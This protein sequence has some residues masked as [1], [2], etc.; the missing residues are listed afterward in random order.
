M[1][2]DVIGPPSDLPISEDAVPVSRTIS[3]I[4]STFHSTAHSHTGSSSESNSFVAAF[5][6]ISSVTNTETEEGASGHVEPSSIFEPDPEATLVDPSGYHMESFFPGADAEFLPVTEAD[7]D[8]SYLAETTETYVI[9]SEAEDD[10]YDDEGGDELGDED[11]TVMPSNRQSTLSSFTGVSLLASPRHSTIGEHA[12]ASPIEEGAVDLLSPVQLSTK[13][14]PF[15][16]PSLGSK[17]KRGDSIDSGYADGDSWASP[18]PFPRSPPR[19]FRSPV[20]FPSHSRRASRSS[21]ALREWRESHGV[22]RA[23]SLN[24]IEVIKE[25]ESEG[26][27]EDNEDTT[28]TILG[29]C[30]TSPSKEQD[31][32]GAH[33]PLQVHVAEEKAEEDDMPSEVLRSPRRYS[34]ERLHPTREYDLDLCNQLSFVS[35]DNVSFRTALSTQ[36]SYEDLSDVSRA[37]PIKQDSLL[38]YISGRSTPNTSVFSYYGDANEHLEQSANQID[39]TGAPEVRASEECPLPED[40]AIDST[41]PFSSATANDL[42]GLATEKVVATRGSPSGVFHYNPHSSISGPPLDTSSDLSPASDAQISAAENVITPQERLSGVFHF[43]KQPPKS[44]PSAARSPSVSDAGSPASSDADDHWESAPENVTAPQEHLP[45]NLD[46]DRRSPRSSPSTGSRSSPPCKNLPHYTPAGAS[47]IRE[48]APQ[49]RLPGSKPNSCSESPLG[50]SS[51]KD[52]LNCASQDADGMHERLPANAN[53]NPPQE[54][55]S[56]GFHFNNHPSRSSLSTE[57]SHSSYSVHNVLARSSHIPSTVDDVLECAPP[58]ADGNDSR[59]PEPLP[60]VLHGCFAEYVATDS[61]Q[62]LVEENSL[63]SDEVTEF[64]ECDS[65]SQRLSFPLPPPFLPAEIAEHTSPSGEDTSVLSE[66]AVVYLEKDVLNAYA[67]TLHDEEM[68]RIRSGPD[69][70]EKA[71]PCELPSVG[72]PKSDTDFTLRR[73]RAASDLTVKGKSPRATTPGDTPDISNPS[74]PPLEQPGRSYSVQSLYDQY[75]DDG[76]SDDGSEFPSPAQKDTAP[77]D[78]SSPIEESSQQDHHQSPNFTTHVFQ[79]VSSSSSDSEPGDS[80]TD[81]PQSETVLR[82]LLTG[83]KSFLRS[84]LAGPIPKAN[85]ANDMESSCPTRPSTRLQAREIGSTMVPLGFRRHKPQVCEQIWLNDP[86][87]HL[88]LSLR[89]RNHHNERYCVFEPT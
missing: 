22:L 1:L 17:G 83:R 81:S 69:L 14:R 21:P 28:C 24:L 78:V 23:S 18:L 38:S 62:A 56:G 25:V 8:T 84:S 31:E 33:D 13:L 66:A 89:R 65:F 59:S 9:G 6:S 4:P 46:Y 7:K 57:G 5:E 10:G 40:V 71:K 16:I 43:D 49:E 41:V 80:H 15:P 44:S 35:D 54:H 87:T 30:N 50:L 47:D 72:L 61:D 48:F 37:S 68:E 86:R 77:P 75:F 60:A 79:R 70:T 73:S 12:V 85:P 82:P 32:G 26:C 55:L 51:V 67:L 27:W 74:P 2:S 3:T 76:T 34:P 64:S 20:T 36:P 63:R 19:S 45:S 53:A 39:S 29:A 42:Q 11:P 58:D 52:V 88:L